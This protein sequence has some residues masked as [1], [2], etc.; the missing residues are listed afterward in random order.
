MIDEAGSDPQVGTGPKRRLTPRGTQRRGQ[1]IELATKRFA[2]DGYHPTS[3][4]DIVDA[5][6]VGKGV[7]Y[8]YFDSKEMLLEEI[9]R[10][11]Q[12]DLRRRQQRAVADIA[13]PIARMERGMRAAV[14]WSYEHHDLANLFES[15]QTDSRFAPLIRA[16]R[17]RLVGDAVPL[18]KDAMVQGMIPDGD[19]EQLGYAIL[20]VSTNLTMVYVHQLGQDPEH[21]ADVVVDFCLRG[22]GAR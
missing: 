6:G 16:G 21:I 15:A 12:K 19:P 20:G 14:L 5:L 22:I 13:D 9:L 4:A 17:A 3:V 2:A 7:F 10:E 8:W 1:L 18:I 11:A